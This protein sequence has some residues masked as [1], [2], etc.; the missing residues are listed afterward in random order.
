[1]KATWL[2]A[3][4]LFFIASTH[5]ADTS[6]FFD[7]FTIPEKFSV[8]VAVSV[9][10]DGELRENVESYLKRELRTL[11]DVQIVE[12]NFEFRIFVIAITNDLGG[13]D[14]GFALGVTVARPM[15][16]LKE[17]A[18]WLTHEKLGSEDLKSLEKL[19]DAELIYDGG[20]IHVCGRNALRKSCESIITSF[21]AKTLEP[22]RESFQSMVTT[23]KA[24]QAKRK[25]QKQA[26][27]ERAKKP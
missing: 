27:A 26:D 23:M 16:L 3:S 4:V 19:F 7:S 12:T 6:N 13:R 9:T 11:G 1:M 5:A 8:K 24:A 20:S 15:S 25:A 2:I 14:S 18:R 17:E 22:Q 10:A 21:D